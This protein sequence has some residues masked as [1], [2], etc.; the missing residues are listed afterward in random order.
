MKERNPVSANGL[1]CGIPAACI[2]LEILLG[3]LRGDGT[4]YLFYPVL[5]ALSAGLMAAGI[6]ASFHF[7]IRSIL[8]NVF[9]FAGGIFFSAEYLIRN[10]YTTY[11]TPRYLLSG[12]GNAAAGYTQ[13]V[14]RSIVFGLPKVL[15]FLI[16]FFM[17]LFK[18]F[19][20]GKRRK[21]RISRKRVGISRR[22]VLR[23][24]VIAA[25]GFL[26]C[27]LS[28]LA[29]SH[30]R[31]S[32]VYGAQF[33]YNQAT[34][35]FGLLTSTRL[36]IQY[37]VFGNPHVTFSTLKEPETAG[38]PSVSSEKEEGKTQPGLILP[39]YHPFPF[40]KVP[41]S[42]ELDLGS[43]KEEQLSEEVM[44]TGETDSAEEEK[45]SPVKEPDSGTP[46]PEDEEGEMAE[47]PAD[48]AQT[49]GQ[50][51]E[52]PEEEKPPVYAPH[53]MEDALTKAE[54]TGSASVDQLTAYIRTLPP[55][56]ENEYTG[57]FKGKN[58]ILICAESYCDAFISEELTPTLW[59]L[60]RNGFC[61]REYYQP[62]WG[63][64]TTT[65]EASFLLGLAPQDGDRTM[66]ESKDNNLYF[67]MGNQLQRLGYSSIAFHGGE[68]T[69]Y[70]R[71]E[72]HENLGYNQFMAN[73]S[74]IKEVCGGTYPRDTVAFSKTMDL[75]L[76]HR[77]FS[78]YYM[79]ISGHAPY[80]KDYAYTQDYY[81][82][83]NAA[84]GDTYAEKTKYYICYQ[85][86]LE[87]AM[88][89]MVEKLEKA[90][91]ADET[92][93]AMVGDHYPYGLGRG[94]AWG[95]DRD[96]INDLIKGDDTV[97]YEQDR[98]GLI[99]WSGCLEN[100]YADLP[101]EIT[102]P[103]F[104]LDV[105]PTLSNLFGL[106][107]DSR[108]FAGRDVFSEAEPLV[109]WNNLSWVTSY[110]KYDARHGIFTPGEKMPENEDEKAYRA[111][112]DETVRNRILMSRSIVE[113][114]YYGILFGPDT[115]T[116]A[117]DLLWQETA[118]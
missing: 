27:L 1:F 6:L 88:K 70:H 12:A 49:D 3:L 112:I 15:L 90:G 48:A 71:D 94:E 55:S 47:E 110:G 22:A 92:V 39:D 10:I 115:V 97:P 17:A 67:T 21:R 4:F 107:Y 19:L 59:R 101:R 7:R 89:I 98:N 86:E 75:F 16:P 113:N 25:A 73:R 79:T 69:F 72:T 116:Q 37:T 50:A 80:K 74:G 41:G 114:D 93:I 61:F 44:E 83:V 99:I 5:F 57:I 111:R 76:D 118:Q 31:Y 38:E 68:D 65:G 100:E 33:D 60:S 58:L 2:C 40:G 87:E 85:M 43:V 51:E 35:L 95:N 23:N 56:S 45:D 96:Y 52:T 81:E 82:R 13:E 109:F 62:E 106:P 84:V 54:N 53:Q 14:L 32:A 108:F 18:G 63:G 102:E 78:V 105:L 36:S 34:S 30:G 64:S 29:A 11:L 20:E 104:S 9:L 28:S 8:L 26:I 91:I 117:G 42:G 103:V 77:P 24:T 46:V 66:L